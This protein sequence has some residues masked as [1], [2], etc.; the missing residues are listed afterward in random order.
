I[1]HL[2]YW[3]NITSGQALDPEFVCNPYVEG[4]VSTSRAVRSGPGLLWFKAAMLPVAALML[5]TWRATGAWMVAQG[6]PQPGVRRWAVR[7]GIGGAIA[8]VFYVLYL[9]TDGAV[10]AW[11][12][13]YG[14]VFFFGL[15]ALAQLVTA[16][17]LWGVFP[18]GAPA[19]AR[20]LLGVV[21]LQWAIGVF[22][23]LKRLLFVDAEF[24]DRLENIT[25]WLMIMCMSL[26][27]I[28]IGLMLNTRKTP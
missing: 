22:S 21:S 15:T 17:F 28:L 10:Y 9:G 18:A 20:M 25:E 27:F 19:V 16:R 24:I 3:L 23:V 7:L 4:C 12:R 8:L 13:R 26:V 6:D 5:I 1:I 11:L 14:V 2:A